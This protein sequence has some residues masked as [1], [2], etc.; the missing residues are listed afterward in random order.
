MNSEDANEKPGSTPAFFFVVR[1]LSF[2]SSLF[3]SETPE[4]TFSYLLPMGI[5][6]GLL[7]IGLASMTVQ[8]HAV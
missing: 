7:V 1:F 6:S 4:V 3:I 2:L 8:A 5:Q